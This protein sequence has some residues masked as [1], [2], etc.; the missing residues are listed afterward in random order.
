MDKLPKPN[1]Q[2][3]S[4]FYGEY[5]KKTLNLEPKYQRNPIWSIG[6]NCFLIDSLIS[7]CPIPQVFLNI[8]SDG[9]GASRKTIYEVVDGQQRLRAILDY[10]EDRYSLVKLTPNSLKEIGQEC[11]MESTDTFMNCK[12]NF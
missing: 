3:L 1:T 7:D 2:A 4:W 8:Q 5:K 10:M 6:Q 9:A 12:R 11:M